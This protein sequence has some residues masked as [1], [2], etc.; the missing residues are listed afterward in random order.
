[1]LKRCCTLLDYHKIK[2][3]LFTSSGVE[4]ETKHNNGG[5][6]WIIPIQ[7]KKAM[8]KKSDNRPK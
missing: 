1:L 7:H 2:V 8:I 5:M 4:Q 6:D 3:I